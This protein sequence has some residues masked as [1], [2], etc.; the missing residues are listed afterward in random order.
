PAGPGFHPPENIRCRKI[1]DCPSPAAPP[2]GRETGGWSPVRALPSLAAAR[3]AHRRKLPDAAGPSHP[4]ARPRPTR[5]ATLHSAPVAATRRPSCRH[6]SP[7]ACGARV[8][9]RE[10]TRP[11]VTLGKDTSTSFIQQIPVEAPPPS[12]N[13][14]LQLHFWF[15]DLICCT[16]A[17]ISSGVSLLAN[18]GIRP[19]PSVITLRKLSVEAAFTFSE[20]SGGPP[21]CR[22]AAVLP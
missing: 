19:L 22:P 3:L 2:A 17:S 20:T 9:R 12:H 14:I 8:A 5:S 6:N 1:P 11:D 21:K 16:S 4:R 15:N 13:Q 7:P 18:F 10:K